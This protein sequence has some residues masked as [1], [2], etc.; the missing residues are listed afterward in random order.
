[1]K[2]QVILLI[3]IVAVTGYPALTVAQEKDVLLTIEPKEGN[4]R[5][6]EGDIIELKDGNI[7]SIRRF[8]GLDKTFP[9]LYTVFRWKR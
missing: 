3:V 7:I 9:D 2:I 8:D 4:P 5:N 1:M 6:S